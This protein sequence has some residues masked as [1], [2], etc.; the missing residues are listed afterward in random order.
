MTSMDSRAARMRL[1]P[2]DILWLK[3]GALV[4][5]ALGI[6]VGLAFLMGWIDARAPGTAA[7]PS[8]AIEGFRSAHFG[9]D[10]AEV[11]SAIAGDFGKR[12]ADV[13]VLDNA[14]EKTRVLAVRV[15]DL[16][17]GSGEAEIGYVL[18]YQ[19][20]RLIQVN[21]LWGTP[22]TPAATAA[23]MGR[24]SMLLQSYF[25]FAGASGAREA[26]QIAEWRHRRLRGRGCEGPLCAAPLPRRRNQGEGGRGE[27]R[28]TG[29]EARHATAC[30]CR[31]SE[32]A[33]YLQAA[34]RHFL[35][36]G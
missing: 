23:D 4:V 8:N 17:P 15:N 36:A 32:I 12:G 28:C 31:R 18:G 29:E 27:G 24:I 21:V 26:P 34:A 25:C 9:A 1:A 35:G 5:L 13:R 10:E 19:S 33:R 14:K 16:F 2:G 20:K 11:L 6:A 7:A 30:L 3:R 22:V